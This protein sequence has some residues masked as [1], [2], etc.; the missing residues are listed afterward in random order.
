MSVAD[1]K[2][3]K[4]VP[5]IISLLYTMPRIPSYTWDS[6]VKSTFE[7]YEKLGIGM[8][9]CYSSNS[10]KTAE[11]YHCSLIKAY[12]FIVI[13]RSYNDLSLGISYL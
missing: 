6:I 1:K 8:M 11:I 3:L 9:E 7:D 12:I 10:L 4:Y 5:L 13:S 2:L